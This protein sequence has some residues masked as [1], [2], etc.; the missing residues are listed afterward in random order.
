MIHVAHQFMSKPCDGRDLQRII[1]RALALGALLPD[2]ALRQVVGQIGQ[3]PIAQQRYDELL[4]LLVRSG[5]GIPEV[6]VAIERDVGLTSKV[7]Q[8]VNSALFASSRPVADLKTAVTILG[9][10]TVKELVLSAEMKEALVPAAGFPLASD[11]AE[12][13]SPS[14]VEQAGLLV[15]ASQMQASFRR[16]GDAARQ[17]GRAM[18]EV[19]REILGVTHLD[20]GAYLLGIWGLPPGIVEAV[21]RPPAPPPIPGPPD[22]AAPRDH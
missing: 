14:L 6:A 22:R 10:E 19:E 2:T 8:V 3:L 7:L 20:I 13:T 18:V 11:D 17:S 9:L 1:E 16:I 21:V 12:G 4:E 15:L 5:A